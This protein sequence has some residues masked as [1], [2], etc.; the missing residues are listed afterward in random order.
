MRHYA[1]KRK[2]WIILIHAIDTM[3]DL[4]VALGRRIFPRYAPVDA[5]TLRRTEFANI[6]AVR[7]DHAGDVLLVLP[8]LRAIRERFPKARVSVL[9]A[10]WSLELLEA[11]DCIDHVLTFDAPW[12]ARGH[13]GAGWWSAIPLLLRLRRERFDLALEFRGDIRHS[14]ILWLAGI[15]VRIGY[16]VTGGGFLLT[17]ELVHAPGQHESEYDLDLVRYLGWQGHIT[18]KPFELKQEDIQFADRL[19]ASLGWTADNVLVIH[20]GAGLRWKRWP[21]DRF[22]RTAVWAREQLGA[23]I[24]VVGGGS[25]SN[26]GETVASGSE[27]IINLCGQL[28]LR[29]LASVLSKSRAFLGND[30][31]PAHIAAAYIPAIVIFSGANDPDRWGPLGSGVTALYHPE[32]CGTCPRNTCPTMKCLDAVAVEEV[33]RALRH[34]WE[35][36]VR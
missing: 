33:V 2:T 28:T 7:L 31:A 32:A 14:L 10:S 11:Q 17:H 23:Q 13:H 22:Q 8:A 29:Q 18:V 6:L 26:L 19:F 16:G 9:A 25:E 21:L 34:I 24:L 4:A 15:R 30:S 27:E 3:G 12:F 36:T 1:F 35:P 20:P 5:T